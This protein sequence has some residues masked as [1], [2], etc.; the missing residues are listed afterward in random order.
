MKLPV[1]TGNYPIERILTKNQVLH[2]KRI[3]RM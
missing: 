1:E 2:S 3:D